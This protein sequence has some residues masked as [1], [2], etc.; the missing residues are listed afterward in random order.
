M[1]AEATTIDKIL[2][3]KSQ[4]LKLRDLKLNFLFLFIF[5]KKIQ[6]QCFRVKKDMTM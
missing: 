1:Q 6:F 3:L 5:L 2:E 4:I